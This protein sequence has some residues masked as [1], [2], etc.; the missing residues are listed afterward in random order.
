[1]YSPCQIF[2][3]FWHLNAKWYYRHPGMW[4]ITGGPNKLPKHWTVCHSHKQPQ[5][6]F[7]WISMSMSRRNFFLFTGKSSSWIK[8]HEFWS[9][10]C[11]CGGFYF[12]F[13]GQ[14][15]WHLYTCCRACRLTSR[16]WIVPLEK[17]RCAWQ[18]GLTISVD[19]NVA[20][21][22]FDQTRLLSR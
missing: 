8:M 21:W 5:F 19:S 6:Q 15:H 12:F 13:N 2:L 7:Q 3:G 1:M 22:F 9:V 10:F 17:F 20:N 11:R 18:L 16:C 14:L 4:G